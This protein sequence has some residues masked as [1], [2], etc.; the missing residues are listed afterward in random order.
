VLTVIPH[1]VKDKSAVAA[2]ECGQMAALIG[3]AAISVMD[4]W[5]QSQQHGRQ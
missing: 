4:S 1:L 2:I 3:V 5:H